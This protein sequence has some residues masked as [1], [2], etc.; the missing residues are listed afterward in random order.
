M[1][2]LTLVT[3]LSQDQLSKNLLENVAG[4]MSELFDV[5]KRVS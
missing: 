4:L 1:Q 5:P 3:N 2:I